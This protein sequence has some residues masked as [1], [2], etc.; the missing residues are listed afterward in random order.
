MALHVFHT[1]CNLLVHYYN[2]EHSYKKLSHII[3]TKKYITI[4]YISYTMSIG[5]NQDLN[6]PQKLN[7]VGGPGEGGIKL[8]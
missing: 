4:V 6:I 2:Y 1:F 7:R 3:I 5:I 8:K